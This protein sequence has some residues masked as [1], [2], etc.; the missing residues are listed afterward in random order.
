MGWIESQQPDEVVWL[1][2]YSGHDKIPYGCF[3]LKERLQDIFSEEVVLS[4]EPMAKV[5]EQTDNE[6]SN[7]ISINNNVDIGTENLEALLN[8]VKRGNQVFISARF[9]E[10]NLLDTLGVRVNRTFGLEASDGFT[11]H[12]ADDTTRYAGKSR[13]LLMGA[14]FDENSAGQRLGMCTD[15]LTNFISVEI[16][17]GTIFLHLLPTA[18]TNIAMLTDNNYEYVSR[19]L[20]RMPDQRT[21]WDEYYKARKQYISKS[22]MEHVVNKDGLRQALYLTLTGLVIY[23]LF[24]S[25]RKQRVIPPLPKIV[26]DT[27]EFVQTIGRLYYNDSSHKEIGLK[28]IQYFL[29]YVHEKYRINVSELNEDFGLKLSS[30]SGVSIEEINKI[31]VNFRVIRAVDDVLDA[32]IIEQESLLEN[33]FMKESANGKR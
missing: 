25:K 28:R 22:P 7:F 15:T 32:R 18:F 33:Y 27:K 26:N 10:Q 20:S 5:F 17:E 12:L 31:M 4:Q 3:V 9:I 1:E 2:S 11:Y 6:P 13:N 14:G 29:S 23:M 16:G 30:V 21:Y 8:Y 19:V 24:A